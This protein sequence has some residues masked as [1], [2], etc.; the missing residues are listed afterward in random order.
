MQSFFRQNNTDNWENGVYACRNVNHSLLFVAP[1][2]NLLSHV[3]FGCTG[4]H[5]NSVVLVWCCVFCLE[6]RVVI[7]LPFCWVRC[8]QAHTHYW[9]TCLLLILSSHSFQFF[10]PVE[11][12]SGKIKAEC[13][14]I[15][16]I[17]LLIL[18]VLTAVLVCKYV[19]KGHSMDFVSHFHKAGELTRNRTKEWSKSKWRRQRYHDSTSWH[20]TGSYISH[21]KTRY[22]FFIF[23]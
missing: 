7:K 2:L 19:I 16:R 17:S 6:R 18:G 21:N 20:D 9:V 10:S 13:L 14:W 5:W 22:C 8:C 11:R 1:C 23:L 3:L 15:L 12:E 4:Q